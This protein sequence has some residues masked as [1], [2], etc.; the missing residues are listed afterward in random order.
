V[1]YP[2]VMGLNIT[3]FLIYTS[4]RLKERLSLSSLL[5]V[6]LC[7]SGIGALTIKF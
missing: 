1:G 5:S 4:F 3:A 6:L 2:V 7:L